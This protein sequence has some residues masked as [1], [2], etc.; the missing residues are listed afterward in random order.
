MSALTIA[1]LLASTVLAA[2]QQTTFRDANG[3]ITGYVTT[4]SNGMRTYRDGSG[5]TTGTA[6]TDS[7][8]TTT[9][10]DGAGRITGTRERERRMGR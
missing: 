4:D 10:R 6:T 5:R 1:F 2:A 3:R 8:G 7:N 9:F